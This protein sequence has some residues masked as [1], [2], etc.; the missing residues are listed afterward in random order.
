MEEI[1]LKRK[2]T[3][4]REGESIILVNE[5]NKAFGVDEVVAYI[6]SI[7]DRKTTDEVINHSSEVSN[8]SVEEVREPLINLIDKLR[9]I[10][11]LE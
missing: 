11:L 5:E 1:R 10:L 9:S 3:L 6:W 4:V 7:I 8:I 2:G